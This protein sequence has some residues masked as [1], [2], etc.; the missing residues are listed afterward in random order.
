M[1]DIFLDM[2]IIELLKAEKPN[3]TPF[4]RLSE[5]LDTIKRGVV[6]SASDFRYVQSRQSR[7]KPDCEHLSSQGGCK[8][9]AAPKCQATEDWK[10]GFIGCAAYSALQTI[11]K[12]KRNPFE[13]VNPDGS[14]R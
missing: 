4:K 8:I 9:G 11:T 12:H 2:A 14:N 10:R 13:P 6:P 7:E 1:A 5:I 3:S